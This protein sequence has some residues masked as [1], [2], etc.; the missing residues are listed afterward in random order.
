MAKA[1]ACPR[2]Q[3]RLDV[4][5]VSPGASVRCPDCG[6]VSRVPT[7]N[8]S[9]RQ[10]V[11]VAPPPAPASE[12]G[13][14]SVRAAV[15]VA[16][17]PSSTERPTRVRNRAP[18]PAPA[19]ARASQAPLLVGIAV[20]TIGIV[21]AIVALMGPKPAP[22]PAAE[23]V[24][25][26]PAPAAP[27]APEPA[28]PTAPSAKPPVEEASKP[29]PAPPRDPSKV[30]WDQVMQALRPGGGFDDVSRPEGA[31]FKMVKDLG[32]AAYP[33][34]VRYIDHEDMMIGRAAVTVLAELSGNKTPL[35][36]EATKAKIKSDWEAWLKSNP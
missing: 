19:P 23:P 2:C 21:V 24:A 3:H 13:K 8:T 4:S 9:V 26:A 34:L 28:E 20:G 25:K 35:P 10:A 16:P 31:A 5:A 29:L 32:K 22:S 14:T 18:R 33:P 30:N 7:G 17:P 27:K 36:N 15:V 11:V 1:I 12:R 6:Q